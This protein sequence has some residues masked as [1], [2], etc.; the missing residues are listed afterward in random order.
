MRQEFGKAILKQKICQK[1][2][3]FIQ[4]LTNRKGYNARLGT[5]LRQEFGKAQDF[6]KIMTVNAAVCT[7]FYIF[8]FNAKKGTQYKARHDFDKGV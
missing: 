8:P 3:N 6:G 1:Q 5:I 7:F 4:L 2:R